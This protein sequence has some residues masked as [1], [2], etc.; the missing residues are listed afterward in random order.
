VA[1]FYLTICHN[2]APS[3]I[4]INDGD[5]YVKKKSKNLHNAICHIL[6]DRWKLLTSTW[7]IMA[8]VVV[9]LHSNWKWMVSA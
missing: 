4:I 6:M 8:I 3:T 7:H 5:Q 2:I 1:I 9:E